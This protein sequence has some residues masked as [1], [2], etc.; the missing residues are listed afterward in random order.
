MSF[1][2][3]VAEAGQLAGSGG[4]RILGIAGAP[5][6]GKSRLATAL[7]DALGERA[8]M[9]GMDGFHLA[10]S[11]LARLGRQNRKGAPDTFDALGFVALLTRLREN[12]DEVVYAP[13]FDRGIEEPIG[14]AVPV[15]QDV[16]LV[17]V[18]GNYLL[19][20]AGAWGGV[21]PL[22]DRCWY[23]D[24]GERIRRDRLIARHRAYGRSPAAAREHALG[25]DEHN[26]RL[27][28]AWRFRADLI[29]HS[30]QYRPASGSDQ[31]EDDHGGEGHDD[32]HDR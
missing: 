13:R 27:I 7:A 23:L 21:R 25:S 10:Q 20:G 9:V 24:P 4:R 19:V 11:E 22:L 17:I 5:G 31:I 15:R 3:L 18:E 12:L 1:A 28:A 32:Q 2:C 16:P 29:I 26:A 30:V 8:R 6:S 14:C